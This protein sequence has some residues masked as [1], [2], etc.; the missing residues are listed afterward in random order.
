MK[1]MWCS[2]GCS[3]GTIGIN[4]AVEMSFT[5][6]IVQG[7]GIPNAESQNME[8]ELLKYL[9]FYIRSKLVP[10]RDWGR[11]WNGWTGVEIGRVRKSSLGR[12]VEKLGG[13]ISPCISPGSSQQKERRVSYSC[14]PQGYTTLLLPTHPFLH[15]VLLFI[16]KRSDH[17]KKGKTSDQRARLMAWW[18]FPSA[19]PGKEEVHWPTVPICEALVYFSCSG[20][21][22]VL[23]FIISQSPYSKGGQHSSS[24]S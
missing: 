13:W 19:L 7:Q 15:S 16:Q 22:H 4:M 1:G 9:L 18:T 14:F 2:A 8:L 17:Y 24:P 6:S 10:E 20:Q 11:T 21:N 3:H 12:Q 23:L 5:S